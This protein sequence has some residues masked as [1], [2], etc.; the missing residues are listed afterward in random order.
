MGSS[1]AT[2][3]T[4]LKA[5]GGLKSSI[6]AADMTAGTQAA[7]LMNT[8][9]LSA[10]TAQTLNADKRIDSADMQAV[11]TYLRQRANA[12]EYV[13]FLNGHGNDNGTVE[14]GFHYL[15]NDGGT[16]RFQGR[17]FVD[18]VADAIYH[19]GFD[20]QNGRYFNEDGNTNETVDDVAGWL[21][22]FLNGENIV[23]GTAGDD[24]LGSGE[25]SSY[26]A[27]A[28][29]E[30]FLAG[31]GND[32]VWADLGHDRVELGKGNDVTGGG[33]GN[34]TLIGQAGNDS[35][36]GEAGQDSLTGG[37]EADRI[38]GGDGND[39]LDGGSGADILYGE[40][41]NDVISG[42]AQKDTLHGQDG[43][44][45]LKG[46]SENDLLYGGNDRDSLLGDL[47]NDTLHGGDSLDTIEGGGGADSVFLW[48]NGKSRDTL[49][50]RVGDSG[51][52]FGTMDRVEGFQTGT[53]KI[54]LVALGI[55]RFE[56]LDYAAGQV[57]SCFY[58]GKYLR[59][60]H[61]GDGVT[62]MMVEFAWTGSLAAGDFLLA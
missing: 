25:Y 58:D 46:G 47:G 43:S 49:V 52:S 41:G 29:D 7:V 16:L 24:E 14:S 15:Q 19:F 22:Y 32:K 3:I 35:L 4:A 26:F 10:I 50:F 38:W 20:I 33:S 59:I 31:D 36:Y 12:A 60:D 30:T 34:D 39:A 11:T 5:D 44:D 21:N 54:N 28:R 61:T 51:R 9:L 27:A 55:T 62:D 6:S 23:Y 57:K 48:E 42:G 37:A 2:L 45:V 53:D 17:D 1:L 8:V 56:A 40:L 13:D 18:T